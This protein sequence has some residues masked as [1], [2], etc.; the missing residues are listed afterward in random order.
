MPVKFQTVMNMI[1]GR[2]VPDCASQGWASAPRPTWC[3]KL[4]SCPSAAN[5]CR[6]TGAIVA[7]AITTGVKTMTLYSPASLILE[8]RSAAKRKPRNV[9]TAK[10]TTKNRPVCQIAF[11]NTGSCMIAV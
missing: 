7:G 6:K 4:L 3:R 10:V 9:C 8:C 2:A 11:Q 1:T 5:I